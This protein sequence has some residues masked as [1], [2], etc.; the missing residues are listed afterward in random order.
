MLAALMV[1]TWDVSSAA[2]T[3][4]ERAL[5]RRVKAAFIYRFTEFITWP[6]AAFT[7]AP[8]VPS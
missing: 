8:T 1:F 2:S 4:A 7:H 3:E 5:E 6:D